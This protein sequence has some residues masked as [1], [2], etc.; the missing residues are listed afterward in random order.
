[1][2]WLTDYSASPVTIKMRT[3]TSR[4]FGDEATSL[5][6]R[7]IGI[8]L[9]RL[10]EGTTT[11]EDIFVKLRN[12]ASDGE[13]AASEIASLE[14]QINNALDNTVAGE[15]FDGSWEQIVHERSIIR[16][17]E[18]NKRPDRVMLKGKQAVVVDFKFGAIKDEHLNQIKTYKEELCAMGYTDVRGYLWYVAAEKVVEV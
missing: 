13:I 7:S 18:S 8:K 12:M 9:H 1:M 6:P 11:R 16:P 3:T 2:A 4:Y 14:Q 17:K 10:F 15:W 5:T